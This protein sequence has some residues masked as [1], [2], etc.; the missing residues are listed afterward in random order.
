M[1][2]LRHR[3]TSRVLDGNPLGDPIARDL[4]VYVPPGYDPASAQRWP[5]VLAIVGYTGTGGSLFNVDP[6]TEPLHDRLDRLI[7]AGAC[8]PVII[9]APD[10]FTRV[11]GNQY[12]NSAGT[13]R[14]EDYLVDEI[15]P[16]VDANYRTLPRGQ[17]GVFGKSSGGYGSIVL[18]MRRPE[19]FC[20]IA[21]HSGDANFELCYTP[22]F[23]GALDAF[24][25]AG[26]PAAWLER[27]WADPNH[28]RERFHKPLNIVGMATHY[29]PNP[30]APAAHLRVDWPF[31][32]ET[33]EHRPAVWARWRAW[34]PVHMVDGHADQL[35][36]LRAI[37]ID[38]GTRDEFALHWGAR[39][40]VQKIRAHG[41]SVRHEEFDDG[42]MN[43]PYRYG[44]SLP[45]LAGAI[46]GTTP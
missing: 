30:E 23:P 7:A 4:F 42:H 32:L 22:D 11:G 5:A 21:D 17:W 15:I 29:S 46:L 36:K 31:D 10:C 20:A 43:I 13:G 26:G 35:R 1:P 16:F 38:C 12:I 6:L 34:D 25:E 18:G 41:I 40:L 19:V 39:A 33:G 24:R 45:L 37:Y 28:R 8:P 44:V 14:Y 2:V 27:Y 9:A 3:L